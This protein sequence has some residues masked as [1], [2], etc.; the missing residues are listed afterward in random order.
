MPG[1]VKYHQLS[2]SE[3]KKCLGDFYSMVALLKTRQDVK[4][5]LKD[6]LTLSETVMISRRIQ[7]AKLLLEGDTYDDI[8][9]QLKVG[10]TT[11][12]QVE[13]WLNNGFGGY[14]KAIEEYR[15]KYPDRSDF[16][17]YG[18]PAFSR[19]WIK[20]KYPMHYLFSSLLNKRK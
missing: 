2:E 18:Y 17:K 11:I 10:P 12:C 16:E 1:K 14:R 9:Q 13:K 3:K 5:F 20:K 4:N 8:R 19:E 15:K 7:I 6:L